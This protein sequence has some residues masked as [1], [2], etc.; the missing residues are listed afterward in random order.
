MSKHPERKER[1]SKF[2]TSSGLEI[3]R[4]YTPDDLSDLGWESEGDLSLPGDYPFT[5]GIYPTMHRGRFWTM[6]Q[7][8]GF[9]SPE[10]TNRRFKYLL[11]QGQTGLSVAFDLPTQMGYDSDHP[12]AEGEVGKVGVAINSLADM[13]ILFD[14]IP[15]EQVSASMTINSTA[16]ILLAMYVVLAEKRKISLEQLSGTVQNDMLKEYIARGTQ[17]FPIEPSMRLTTDIIEYCAKELPNWNAIS[18]SGYHMREA[19]CDAVQEVAFTLANAIAYLQEA[20]KRH[21]DLDKLADH[22]SFFFGVHNNFFE[23]V[24]KFRAARR[25][26]A[27]IMK[28]RFKAKS[29]SSCRLRFHA[30]TCGSTLTAEQPDNNVVRTSLQALA[31][32][33]GGVQSLHIDSKDEALS[34]PS[35]A[36]VELSL[37]THQ[38]I[39]YESGVADTVDP[40]GGSYYVEWLTNE[41]EKRAEALIN[42]IDSLGGAVNCVKSGYIQGL[43]QQKA[44]QHQR[45][46]EDKSTIIVGVNDFVTDQVEIKSI[47]KVD[48]ALYAKQVENIKKFK[49]GRKLEVIRRS[50]NKLTDAAKTEVNLMPYIID[51]VRHYATIGEIS[52]A[53][54]SQFG[55]WKED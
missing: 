39:A 9:A 46:L 21:L 36:A 22:F 34:I 33:L 5:R 42:Q 7:Y 14:S 35:E 27:K 44:Y 25:L 10:E 2:Y 47:F 8:A 32:V 43:I 18:V 19:G 53:L 30:Q 52:E 38:I 48:E 28:Q 24:A 51:C 17:R 55:E 16:A 45:S 4:L 20:L 3:K 23:E 31:A 15:L 50:L 54:S 29:D 37:R 40:M 26:W 41:L 13:E 1:K 49:R 11:E 12:L 6:R